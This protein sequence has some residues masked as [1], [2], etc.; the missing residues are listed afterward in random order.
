[1]LRGEMSLD[2]IGHP[3][4]GIGAAA[5]LDSITGSPHVG[6]ASHLLALTRRGDGR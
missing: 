4:R 1:M 5:S 2:G 3:R 6:R